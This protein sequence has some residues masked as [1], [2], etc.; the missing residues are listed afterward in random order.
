MAQVRQAHSKSV[1]LR[2]GG[3]RKSFPTGFTLA[4]EELVLE[5]GGF[6]GFLGPNGAGKTVLFETLSLLTPP[7]EGE[8]ELLGECIFPAGVG[9]QQDRRQM[10]MVIQ[11][12]YLFR[13]TVQGN[14]AYGLR[15]RGIGRREIATKVEG[16]L[17]RMGLS[18]LART[19]VRHLSGGEVARVA[20]ARALVLE[21]A[22]LLLDEPTAHVD[23]EQVATVE[24]LLQ[25]LRREQ[26]MTVLLSTHDREQAYRL[27]DEVFLLLSGRLQRPAAENALLGP[28]GL[29]RAKLAVRMG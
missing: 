19:S 28:A 15:A 6:Y 29:K 27:S 26:R 13:G 21:P 2:A 1:A 10:T 24:G 3:I 20:I 25:E 11:Q 22:V 16:M 23:A 7:D 9:R 14:V 8:I 18:G 5:G 17:E 4:V 12:P